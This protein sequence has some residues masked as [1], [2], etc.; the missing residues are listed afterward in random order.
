MK[1]EPTSFTAWHCQVC[2]K[3]IRG[4]TGSVGL[5]SLTEDGRRSYPLDEPPLRFTVAHHK[6]DPGEEGYWF[7]CSRA[8]TAEVWMKWAI[9]LSEKSWF[10]DPRS[11][12]SRPEE[13]PGFKLKTLGE[14]MEEHVDREEP[15]MRQFLALWFNG[16]KRQRG[17]LP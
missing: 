15:R 6:C 11:W 2:G 8:R 16:H 12:D 5:F 17:P 7:N 9:H 13:G 1:S 4:E 10:R 3:P 14:L